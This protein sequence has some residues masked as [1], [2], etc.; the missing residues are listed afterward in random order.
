MAVR[1]AFT[2][3]GY[4][5]EDATIDTLRTDLAFALRKFI[6]SSGMGQAKIGEVLGLK[7][8]V[9]SQIK[10]GNIE[11]LSVERLIRAMVKAKIPGH[12]EWG[13][14][15]EDARAGVG[16]LVSQHSSTL[17]EFA[18]TIGTYY[19]NWFADTALSSDKPWLRV[20]A[21]E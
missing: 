12:A 18:P 15:A 19:A 21:S 9:V 20:K 4:A 3:F 10:R 14:S 17:V 11:H 7:Q 16:M 8:S 13:T 6:E 5:P 2:A 1:N